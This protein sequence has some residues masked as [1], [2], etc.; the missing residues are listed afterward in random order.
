MSSANT[1]RRVTPT[2]KRLAEARGIGVHYSMKPGVYEEDYTKDPKNYVVPLPEERRYNGRA[3]M[4]ISH[5][6]YSSGVDCATEFKEFHM[7]K[8]VGQETGGMD[9]CYID[10]LPFQ[11]NYSGLQGLVSHNIQNTS[12][13]T[14][15]MFMAFF[16]TMR[17]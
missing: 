2:S 4:L 5:Y 16:P 8:V 1:I 15:N 6:T 13:S 9:A 11:L 7:G 17:C 12:A 10:V 3:W 14:A